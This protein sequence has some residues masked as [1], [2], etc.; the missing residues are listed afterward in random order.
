MADPRYPVPPRNRRGTRT[1]YTTGSCAAAAATAATQALIGGAPVTNVTIDLPNGMRASF[2]PVEWE[3]THDSARCCIVKDAGDDPDVT[4]GALICARV[5]WHAVPGVHLEGGYGVG[6]VT[7]PGLG[8]EV[9]GPAINPVPRAQIIGNVSAAAGALLATRGLEVIIEVPEGPELARRT[10]NPKLGIIGGISILGTSGIVKPYS[11]SAWRAAVIQAVELA[12]QHHLE[13]VV[14]TT[15]SRTEKY[16]QRL[17]PDLPELAFAEL[18]V[19]T[20]AGL[21]A[22]LESGVRAV[23]FVSMIGKLVK[24][25]QGHLT[26]HVAGNQ[27]DLEFLARIAAE[28]GAAPAVVEQIRQATTARHFYEI[29]LAHGLYTPFARLVELALDVCY[30]FIDGAMDLEVILVDFEGQ[31]LARAARP[32]RVA[33]PP[34]RQQRR[35]LIERLAQ[36]EEADEDPPIAEDEDDHADRPA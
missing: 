22:A 32:R 10:L 4:H 16:A 31:V 3:L 1:G 27:V 29:C 26:T 33:T 28:S 24:T 25:A 5:R 18:S 6:R 8:L 15:G 2:T 11:T 34:P 19:F 13:R 30:R 23:V 17:F 35:P 14:L 21:R 7:L 12:A 36:G 9:G 20:G